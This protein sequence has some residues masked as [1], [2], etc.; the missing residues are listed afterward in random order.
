M[1]ITGI[2]FL[3]KVNVWQIGPESYS[4]KESGKIIICVQYCIYLM[5]V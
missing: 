3:K 2:D 1:G 4:S 5:L